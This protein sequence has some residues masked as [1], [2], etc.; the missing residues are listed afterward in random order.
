MPKV[1]VKAIKENYYEVVEST[2]QEDSQV[3]LKRVG[4][5]HQFTMNV[6]EMED[7]R[8]MIKEVLEQRKLVPIEEE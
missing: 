8:K 7:I 4:V 1:Y 3:P 2:C 6:L 5:E